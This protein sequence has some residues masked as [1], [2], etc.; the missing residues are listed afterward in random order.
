MNGPLTGGTTT[1]RDRRV[2]DSVIRFRRT[3]AHTVDVV[4][5]SDAAQATICLKSKR[6]ALICPGTGGA[7]AGWDRCVLDLIIIA[8]VS[9]THA[10]DVIMCSDAAR[11]IFARISVLD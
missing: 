6:I 10:V 3:T 1:G 11:S 2:L 8:I 7:A 5:F 9:A 4:V